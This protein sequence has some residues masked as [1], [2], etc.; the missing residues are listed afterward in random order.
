M[1]LSQSN[2][3][4]KVVPGRGTLH[5]GRA[6]IFIECQA[7]SARNQ[8][9]A[10][11]NHGLY[12]TSSKETIQSLSQLLHPAEVQAHLIL[13][14]FALLRFPYNAF[15]YKLKACGNGAS[16]KSAG[17]IFPVAFAHFM[18]LCHVLVILAIFQTFSLLLYLF[19]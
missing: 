8:H 18:S 10:I 13:L 6:H 3:A 1:D 11:E 17:T 15:F 4:V 5:C 14:W 9:F 7:V 2:M 12:P 19:W 16:S